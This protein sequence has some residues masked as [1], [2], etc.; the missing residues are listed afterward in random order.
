MGILED[1][2]LWV[3]S[4]KKQHI[5][6]LG[7]TIL[8]DSGKKEECK[9][10]AGV[11]RNKQ[12]ESDITPDVIQHVLGISG[13]LTA[14]GLSGPS[15]LAQAST[16]TPLAS[17]TIPLHPLPLQTPMLLSPISTCQLSAHRPLSQ[18]GPTHP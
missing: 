6:T 14:Y 4:C 1:Y 8:R 17:A 3:A 5:S 11:K 13:D 16:S 10:K 2:S 12:N 9:W 7:R 15:T 18:T